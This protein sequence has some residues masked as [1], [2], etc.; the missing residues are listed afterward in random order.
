MTDIVFKEKFIAFIDILGFKGMV[1]EAEA[2][3]YKDL[4]SLLQLISNLGNTQD[5][6]FYKKHGPEVCPE[7]PKINKDM[8][9][10]ITQISDCAIVSAE[11]SPAGVV[12]LASHCAK[13]VLRLL[14]EGVMCRGYITRGSVYHTTSQ[15]IGSGYNEA[16]SKESGVKA[17]QNHTD[18]LGTP[19]IE[20]DKAVCEYVDSI[21]DKCT[22][23]MFSRVV[24]SDGTVTA[25]FPFQ[26]LS[27][28]FGI[29][30]MFAEFDAEKEKKSN[31]NVKIWIN[32]FKEKVWA[33]VDMN[34]DSA[35]KKAKH[36]IAILD[37]QLKICEE[38]D[39]QIERL[40]SPFPSTKFPHKDD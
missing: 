36:Y 40:S 8:D 15:I 6:D 16:F 35:V 17:F 18:E 38:T 28:S 27:H 32:T 29:G 39:K 31:E 9:F 7:S 12:N 5:T 3:L 19:F 37:H 14:K 21:Q 20:I 30:R 4:P 22:K 26:R 34:N 23:D 10:V 24:K 1:D 13:V 11:I 25:I 2:G 33:Q